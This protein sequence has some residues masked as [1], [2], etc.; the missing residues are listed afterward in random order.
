MERIKKENKE[1]I[2]EMIKKAGSEEYETSWNKEG[3]PVSKKKTE[4]KRGRKS[5]ARGARFELIVR[6]DLESKG[7]IVAKWTNNVE[8]EKGEN[9]AKL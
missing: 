7:W 9:E 4:I 8:F 2:M 5:R 6:E 3:I 1:K